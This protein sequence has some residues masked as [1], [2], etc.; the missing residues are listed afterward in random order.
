MDLHWR[1]QL[2]PR[3]LQDVAGS[4]CGSVFRHPEYD[5]SGLSDAPQR[6]ARGENANSTWLR[7]PSRALPPTSRSTW[8]LPR[9]DSPPKH[10]PG[11][12]TR[13]LLT[14]RSSSTSQCCSRRWLPRSRLSTM[15]TSSSLMN[16]PPP[17]L[18][19]EW[20]SR[21][22]AREW[23]SASARESALAWVLVPALV[24]ELEWASVSV[25]VSVWALESARGA[26]PVEE[27]RRSPW[28]YQVARS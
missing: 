13:R 2:T 15:S 9:P 27:S 17:K 20:S 26:V 23:A 25:S 4:S 24:L 5:L 18:G 10:S 11:L 14:P 6:H 16:S 19:R 22:R 21:E 12:T 3:R 28:E 7:G 1:N 8:N